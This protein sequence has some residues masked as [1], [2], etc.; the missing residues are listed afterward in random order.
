MAGIVAV[1]PGAAVPDAAC[2]ALLAG[3]TARR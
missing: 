3:Y 2:A 1:E